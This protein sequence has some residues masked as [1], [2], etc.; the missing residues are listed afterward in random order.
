M[1]V[2]YINGEVEL[3]KWYQPQSKGWD[4]FIKDFEMYKDG[5]TIAL[6]ITDCC[7]TGAEDQGPMSSRRGSRMGELSTRRRGKPVLPE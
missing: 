6:A 1:V 2:L 5:F 3:K 7:F 4:Q